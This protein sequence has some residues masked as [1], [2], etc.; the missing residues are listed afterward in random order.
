VFDP[1]D[2]SSNIECNIAVGTIFGIYE[3]LSEKP[4]VADVL[5]PGNQLVAAG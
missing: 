5:Q 4:G 1:L 3:T 2:G